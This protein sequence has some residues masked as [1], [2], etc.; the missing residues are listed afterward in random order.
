MK[1]PAPDYEPAGSSALKITHVDKPISLCGL[2]GDISVL[3]CIACLIIS[4]ADNAACER[5]RA[6]CESLPLEEQFSI[7]CRRTWCN[8]WAFIMISAI[9]WPFLICFS[10]YN[11]N[12]TTENYLKTYMKTKKKFSSPEQAIAKVERY[13][14]NIINTKVKAG[15]EVKC[16]HRTTRNTSYTDSNGKHHRRTKTVTVTTFCHTYNFTPVVSSIDNSPFS[17]DDINR[18]DYHNAKTK[19]LAFDSYISINV[20]EDLRR[21][22]E[23]WRSHLQN[24]NRHRDVTVNATVIIE[25]ATP[26]VSNQMIPIDFAYSCFLTDSTYCLFTVFGCRSL[27]EL[28]IRTDISTCEINFK[29]SASMVPNAE[30][31]SPHPAGGETLPMSLHGAGKVPV[32]PDGGYSGGAGKV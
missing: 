28:I 5:R 1:H 16:S 21:F 25:P 10:C 30:T 18:L 23:A 27:Y 32:S 6:S 24:A 22:M 12:S 14:Q 9:M 15:I 29:K 8:G 11:H 17:G 26:L 7:D 20:P 3:V 19:C 4:I 2:I 31:Y 13:V